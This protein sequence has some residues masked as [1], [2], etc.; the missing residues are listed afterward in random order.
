MAEPV[1]CPKCHKGN[2]YV[3]VGGEIVCRKC[4]YDERI[5]KKITDEKSEVKK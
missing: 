5:D 2:I 3:L 4:G 1:V